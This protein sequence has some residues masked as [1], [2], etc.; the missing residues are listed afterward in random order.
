MKF[1]FVVILVLFFFLPTGAK[2]QTATPEQ[3]KAVQ[4]EIDNFKASWHE[5][6]PYD[7]K[8][9]II[10]LT[11]LLKPDYPG[12]EKV[13]AA[14]DA[15]NWE[16]AENELL[17]Y[18]KNVRKFEL[19]VVEKLSVTETEAAESALNHYF[20]GNKDAHPLI[21]RG[22]DI[23]WVSLAV[24]EGKEIKDAEWQ[25]SFQRLAWWEALAKAYKLTKD[26]KYYYEWLYE[27]VDFAND[28]LPVS[29]NAP[30][31]I[32]RGMETYYRC[33]RLRY[34][35][36]FFIH[37]KRFD[38]KTLLYLLSSFHMQADHIP[39]VYAKQGNHLLGELCT[40]FENGIFFPE[41]KKSDEWISETVKRIPERMFIEIYPDGMN[42]ELIFSYH[43]MYL[44]LFA[45]AWDLFRKNGY[46]KNLPGE[47]HD[48]LVK[49]ADIYL[50]Q[51]FPDFTVS[52]FG[53]AWK[54]RD[55]TSLFKAE[56][57]KFAPDYPYSGFM[58]SKG[59]KGMPPNETCV[60]YPVSGFYFF[61]SEWTPAAVFMSMKNNP[62]YAWH[63]QFDN[64]SFELY[65]YGRNFMI[66]SGSYIYDS[67]DP[68]EKKWR[69]WFRS[70]FVHQTVTLNNKDINIG[71]QHV[72]WKNSERL[73]C[74]IYENKSYDSLIHRRTTLF[75]DKKYF[76]IYD[77]A[78]GNAA[79]EVRS[80]FQFVPCN[81]SSDKKTNTVTTL[82]PEGPNLIVKNFPSGHPVR[83]E[84]EEGWI[85]YEILRKEERPAWS[86]AI[87]KKKKQPEVSFLTA[88]VPFQQGRKPVLLDA[89]VVKKQSEL[90]FLFRIDQST[91]RIKLDA[92]RG[93]GEL[94]AGEK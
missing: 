23:D 57:P 87:D 73:S 66:D 36:P 92:D 43:A 17:N 69:Q 71:S 42:N 5:K 26:E 60:A 58:V 77:Q 75:I 13:R 51:T 48:R 56:V 14:V 88:L 30:Y 83:I 49:M 89:S 46:D 8:F 21:F 55:A 50:H 1:N 72:F 10:Q 27:M 65:A 63:S 47:F 28:I 78:I 37:D 80:H 68:E 31:Y 33:I 39:K 74:L 7:S 93:I 18:F 2:T 52:Q 59:Q 9:G 12:L 34:V 90:H 85:S 79:G 41:F 62:N 54:Q 81:Y 91:F 70:S 20:R 35:L 4:A 53:D 40:V 76:L 64:G 94:V 16:L 86:F 32:R 11:N 24:H 61:R 25:Y 38:S 22:S 15:K 67:G 45:D 84:K 44:R 29:K 6:L 19:P 3:K 82:F